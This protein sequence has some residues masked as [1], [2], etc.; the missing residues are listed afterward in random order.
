MFKTTENVLAHVRGQE[1]SSRQQWLGQFSDQK[2][3]FK[4]TSTLVKK[5]IKKK[6]SRQQ[7]LGQVS[8]QE[9]I[10]KMTR[11]VKKCHPT[12]QDS[13]SRGIGEFSLQSSTPEVGKRKQK[14][15][16]EIFYCRNC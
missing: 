9:V 8:D 11:L 5:V 3:I 10:Y 12:L 16:K 2:V 1:V 15:T 6:S 14:A 7:C 13:T 4:M